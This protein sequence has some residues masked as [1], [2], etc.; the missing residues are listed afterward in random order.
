MRKGG[1]GGADQDLKRQPHSGNE[2]RA[3][4]A[5]VVGGSNSFQTLSSLQPYKI[6]LLFKA[7]TIKF[8]SKVLL[9]P[10]LC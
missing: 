7:R 4:G 3:N 8:L 6:P 10:Y 2:T 9:Y 1:T 5:L